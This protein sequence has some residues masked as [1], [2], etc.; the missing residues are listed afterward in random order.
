[1]DTMQQIQTNISEMAT[2]LL[3][4]NDHTVGIEQFL[5]DIGQQYIVSILNLH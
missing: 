2:L 4:M 5:F 3:K 1:V